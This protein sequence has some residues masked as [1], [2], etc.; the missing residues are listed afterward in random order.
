MPHICRP[1]ADHGRPIRTRQH[2]GKKAHAHAHAHPD[3]K[4]EGEDAR[5]LEKAKKALAK[6][7]ARQMVLWDPAPA[8]AQLQEG[9][10]AGSPTPAEVCYY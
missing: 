9:K 1:L 10:E 5:R 8:D 4:E 2:M 7:V 3:E 6:M